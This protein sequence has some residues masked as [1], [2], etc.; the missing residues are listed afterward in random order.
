MCYKETRKDLFGWEKTLKSVLKTGRQLAE[1]HL[2]CGILHAS[3]IDSFRAHH[4]ILLKRTVEVYG[5]DYGSFIIA[6]GLRQQYTVHVELLV[7]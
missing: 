1:M 2:C 6:C 7:S 4:T 5:T 3:N